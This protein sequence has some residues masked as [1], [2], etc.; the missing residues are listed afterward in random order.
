MSV[1][2]NFSIAG[3]VLFLFGYHTIHAQKKE[4]GPSEHS[5]LIVTAK[6]GFFEPLAFS[7][8]NVSVL[9]TQKVRSSVRSMPETLFGL[10]SVLVQKTALGQ[11]SPYIRGLTGYHNVLLVL[12]LIH[13]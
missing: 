2:E 13:I 6:V 11:S 9:E 7:P 5:P 12:S 1:K 3:I 4:D 8:W 10:P